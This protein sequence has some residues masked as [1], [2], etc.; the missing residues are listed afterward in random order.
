MSFFV[1]TS[2]ITNLDNRS[3]F[4]GRYFLED[5]HVRILFFHEGGQGTWVKF[6]CCWKLSQDWDF[7]RLWLANSGCSQ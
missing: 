3:Y 6:V 4:D 5:Y 2:L 7:F 1:H